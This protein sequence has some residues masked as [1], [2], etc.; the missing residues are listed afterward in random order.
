MPTKIRKFKKR[1]SHSKANIIVKGSSIFKK[2]LIFIL[3]VFALHIII[4]YI[5]GYYKSYKKYGQVRK[6]EE[7]LSSTKKENIRLKKEI[8]KLKTDEE[9]ERLAR[10]NLGLVKKGEVSFIIIEDKKRK[11]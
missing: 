11:E 6:I 2:F 9:I 1:S 10:E 8:E 5:K 7:K 3:I 4:N